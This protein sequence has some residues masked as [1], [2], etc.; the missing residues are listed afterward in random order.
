[1]KNEVSA[2]LHSGELYDPMDPEITEVQS[3]AVMRLYE[4]NQTAPQ[5]AEKRQRLLEEMLW[6]CGEGCHIEPPFHAN[7]GG[8]FLHLG[9]GVYANFSLTLVDDTHIYIGDHTLIGP[10][11]TISTANHPI[12]PEIRSQ[13]WQYNLPIHIGK[14]CWLGSGVIISAGVTI[15]DN[16]VIGAGSVVTNDIPADSLAFGTPCRV[17]RAI[18][19][20]DRVYYHKTTRI[21]QEIRKQF[22]L[23]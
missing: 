22:G 5:E 1:M 20:T 3:R 21:P 10:N 14:N 15:G 19:E 11:V 7:W 18:D 4:Y 12:N 9:E 23:E 17:I 8:Y 2:K 13:G 16:T 6:E